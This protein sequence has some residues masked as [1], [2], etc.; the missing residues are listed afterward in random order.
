MYDH[1]KHELC[2]PFCGHDNAMQQ[3][4][5]KLPIHYTGRTCHFLNIYCNSILHSS[6]S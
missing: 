4:N 6:I 2:V 3:A 1:K 5:T